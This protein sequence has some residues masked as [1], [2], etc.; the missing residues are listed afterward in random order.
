MKEGTIVKIPDIGPPAMVVQSGRQMVKVEID[1]EQFWIPV[2]LID[3]VLK[4]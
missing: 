4:A 1:G 3:V 2:S